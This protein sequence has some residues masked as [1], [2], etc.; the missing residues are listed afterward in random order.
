MDLP[1]RNVLGCALTINNLHASAKFPTSSDALFASIFV[2]YEKLPLSLFDDL[3]SLFRHNEFHHSDVTMQKAE[4]IMDH[5][6]EGRRASAR[7]REKRCIQKTAQT[8]CPVPTLVVDLVVEQIKSQRQPLTDFNWTRLPACEASSTLREMS[9]VHSSW[10]E[11]TQRVLRERLFVDKMQL[12]FIFKSPLLGPWIRE[13]DFRAKP[14][15]YYQDSTITDT[16]HIDQTR[17]LCGIIER[18]PNLTYLHLTDFCPTDWDTSQASK[19]ALVTG[20]IIRRACDLKYLEH[21][22]LCQS[23]NLAYIDVWEL[24]TLLPRLQCLKSLSLEKLGVLSVDRSPDAQLTQETRPSPTL[25]SISLFQLF[26]GFEEPMFWLTH[27][28]AGYMI[29]RLEIALYDYL[30]P[31]STYN[32]RLEDFL[33]NIAPALPHISELR[34][35]NFGGKNGFASIIGTMSSLHSLSL[36]LALLHRLPVDPPLDIPS[37]VRNLHIHLSGDPTDPVHACAIVGLLSTSPHIRKLSMSFSASVTNARDGWSDPDT[38][39]IAAFRRTL[40][41]VVKYCSSNGLEFEVEKLN[42][43]P[44]DFYHPPITS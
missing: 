42:D 7:E 19:A 2:K 21:L 8:D 25:E 24:C 36:Y 5:I 33:R 18:C 43:D 29:K 26:E 12:H 38:L 17:L 6:A 22:R 31:D 30:E 32:E 40:V 10:A 23:A 37:S 44:S 28:R 4:D 14:T 16:D 15:Y 9:L 35:N 1:F 13:L 34:I 11:I 27:P 41:D 3:L 39:S 20:P